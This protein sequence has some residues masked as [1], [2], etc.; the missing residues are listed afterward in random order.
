MIRRLLMFG[1]AFN[2]PH[3]GHER[4][5]CS[6]IEAIKPDLTL[7]IPSEVSP[8]KDNA[9]VP[10]ADRAYMSRTFKDCG[11]NIRISG[12]E[13][14]GRRRKSYTIKTVKRLHKNYPQAELFLLVGSDMLEYFE[15][16]HLYRRLVSMVTLVAARRA[17]HDIDLEQC[18][19]KIRQ[20]RG[21]VLLLTNEPVVVSS[22][23]VRDAL[24]SKKKTDGISAFVQQYAEK[25]KL[26]E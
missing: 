8:H 3:L 16:W 5:L 25:R 9:R 13:N 15:H 20:L 24:R 14:S 17:V 10:F 2:P 4:L 12:M 21:K 7:V 6:A 11:G 26:Y 22:T 1:G 19:H 18:A 23:E